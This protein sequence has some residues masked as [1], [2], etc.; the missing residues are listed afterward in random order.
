MRL[1][2]ES[3]SQTQQAN[4]LGSAPRSP[5]GIG[6]M[7]PPRASEDVKRMPGPALVEVELPAEPA[8]VHLATPPLASA[9]RPLPRRSAASS[10]Q[11]SPN[12]LDGVGGKTGVV[13]DL[14][15]PNE[16][17]PGPAHMEADVIPV[18][19]AEHP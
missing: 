2:R 15:L 19:I 13:S 3:Q 18:G 10:R 16:S 7:R 11:H 17:P 5:A 12:L 4:G 1:R 9:R 8:A 6:T 14:D